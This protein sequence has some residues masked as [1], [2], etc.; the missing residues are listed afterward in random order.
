M[1]ILL[2]IIG[3]IVGSLITF[4]IL[5]KRIAKLQKEIRQ[6]KREIEKY[7]QEYTLLEQD[8]DL[9][10][11]KQIKVLN[12]QHQAEI[13]DLDKIHHQQLDRITQE[14]E[15]EIKA[16]ITEKPPGRESNSEA[17][18]KL[19]LVST[20]SS[21]VEDL[22]KELTP[23]ETI[24]QVEED[25]TPELTP[26]ETIP[27][28]EEDWTPELTPPET[29]PQV[30]ENWTP[31]FTPSLNFSEEEY[32][33]FDE[34]DETP[35]SADLAHREALLENTPTLTS[36][37]FDYNPFD[38]DTEEEFKVVLEEEEESEI[39]SSDYVTSFVDNVTQ[40]SAT[41][42][43]EFSFDDPQ[44]ESLEFPETPLTVN[45]DT[46][47]IDFEE[48][49]RQGLISPQTPVSL[50]TD[51]EIIDFEELREQ[52]LI[53]PQTPVS[54]NTDTEI[55]DFEE[56]E[57]QEKIT[58]E[59]PVLFNHDTEPETPVSLNTDA[60]P[61][62]ISDQL[63]DLDSLAQGFDELPV[64]EQIPTITANSD[65]G[66]LEPFDH[67]FIPQFEE[68]EQVEE[69]SFIPFYVSSTLQK[70]EL[71]TDGYVEDP[72]N[73]TLDEELD[74]NDPQLELNMF[75]RDTQTQA[76]DVPLNTETEIIG[77]QDLDLDSLSI[78][79]EESVG[80]DSI[81]TTTDEVEINDLEE[82]DIDSL[83]LG[84]EESPD[85]AEMP[86]NTFDSDPGGFE[87]FAVDDYTE[88][89]QLFLISTD[90]NLE[91][92]DMERNFPQEQ[93]SV[94]NNFPELVILDETP[95]NF[96]SDTLFTSEETIEQKELQIVELENFDYNSSREFMFEDFDSDSFDESDADALDSQIAQFIKPE[97]APLPGQYQQVESDQDISYNDL[98]APSSP[99]DPQDDFFATSPSADSQ[100]DLAAL[101]GDD[102]LDSS[103]Q[104]DEDLDDE[105]SGLLSGSFD[106]NETEVKSEPHN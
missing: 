27:Q 40:S 48:L 10:L 84:F 63:I 62:I 106:K 1:E 52:G 58:Q 28:V 86:I 71:Y 11:Q 14:Y 8:Y 57:P 5:Q 83:S 55:I 32:N 93:V 21:L 92:F 17:F 20:P 90:S 53:S 91:D 85:L 94:D 69:I 51:T 35:D 24:L 101:F 81:P 25:W 39:L 65:P 61:E 45:T 80:L 74:T 100:D 44:H 103:N 2:P 79:F 77:F 19:K 23:P 22:T 41:D 6:Q 104:S 72:E 68:V 26:P 105:V 96:M 56:L 70:T 13:E 31:E 3:I 30:E 46:E 54:L 43:E 12:Q 67:S 87:P 38:L 29:I 97:D 47:I 64:L 36:S 7:D 75:D 16:I 50:N 95:E 9:E 78:G 76:E 59:T 102:D 42:F 4:F 89:D 88:E 99:E 49:R 98:F 37:S 34:E 18:E 33:P 60:T 66:D 15:S 73:L 82:I